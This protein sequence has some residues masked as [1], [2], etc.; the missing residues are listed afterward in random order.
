[1]PKTCAWAWRAPYRRSGPLRGALASAGSFAGSSRDRDTAPSAASASGRQSTPWM[2][3]YPCRAM[4]L[5]ATQT[6]RHKHERAP[7]VR[8]SQDATAIPTARAVAVPVHTSQCRAQHPNPEQI[9]RRWTSA[10]A[11]MRTA[12]KSNEELRQVK[13]RQ[14]DRLR[15]IGISLSQSIIAILRGLLRFDIA[16]LLMKAMRSEPPCRKTLRSLPA[17]G[18]ASISA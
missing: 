2:S 12:K 11:E 14:Q 1:M 10:L 13:H 3:H 9:D 16:C 18:C 17:P 4:S 5:T 15:L 6:E 8:P 7:Q